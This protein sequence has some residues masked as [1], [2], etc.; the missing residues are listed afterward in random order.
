[1]RQKKIVGGVL[2]SRRCKKKESYNNADTKVSSVSGYQS[3]VIR[4]AEVD[5]HTYSF[6]LLLRHGETVGH[7]AVSLHVRF[8]RPQ[9]KEKSDALCCSMPEVC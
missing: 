5:I 7:C 8:T 1:M 2:N 3:R 6:L 9:R 4:R